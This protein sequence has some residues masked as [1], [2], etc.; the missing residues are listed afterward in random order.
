MQS[1]LIIQNEQD[2]STI[3]MCLANGTW[4]VPEA[5]FSEIPIQLYMTTKRLRFKVDDNGNV[6]KNPDGK[7]V[8]ER[9]DYSETTILR[10]Q[11][12][13]RKL[14]EQN[15]EFALERLA[16]QLIDL[17][18]ERAPKAHTH[19]NLLEEMEARLSPEHGELA[20]PERLVLDEK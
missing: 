20:N 4:K 11:K 1:A 10:A 16:Q 9:Y 13:L 3:R 2:F 15:K 14:A 19:V 8:V 6:L 5:V 7:P 12:E 17:Q 18:E